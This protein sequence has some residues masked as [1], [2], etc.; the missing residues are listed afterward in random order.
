MSNRELKVIILCPTGQ[1]AFLISEVF[2]KDSVDST[3]VSNIEEL[4]HTSFEFAGFLLIAEEAL[5][6]EGIELLNS[7][8]ASQ[9]PW[10]DIPTI[11]LTS[12]GARGHR[13]KVK[14]MENF[15]T[16]G[17]VSILERPLQKLTLLS[18]S[19][20]AL[21]SRRRQFQVKELINSLEE[22]TKI[23]DEF[24][25]IAGHELK[26]PLT[27]MKLQAQM[28][29]KQLSNTEKFTLDRVNRHLDYTNNQIARLNKLVD[30]MLDISR[31][32]TG[33]MQIMKSKLNLSN[34]LEELVERFA[35]QFEAVNCQVQKVI[36]PEIVGNWDSYKLEQV[37]NNLFSNAI[38]YSANKP[39]Q[40]N[41]IEVGNTAILNVKDE[42]PGI[43]PEDIERIFER[44]ERVSSSV[45]GLGL[46]LYITRQIVELHD[47]KIRV[48]SELGKGAN[49][50]L[51]LPK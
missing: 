49:F 46:G 47:G 15:I 37:I 45:S 5:S 25:S 36:T 44:F 14:R 20:V 4:C 24:I 41:L 39:V 3:I 32:N 31:I 28:T 50:I 18:S 9:E 27:S 13:F 33:K 17:N 6:A 26:T 22:V 8:L 29:K 38:R 23:R 10:S 34:L 11:L 21:R 30:D 2:K 42:G 35:P 1:D 43:P 12:G 19:H 40:I 51:E 16:S 7:R 48:E